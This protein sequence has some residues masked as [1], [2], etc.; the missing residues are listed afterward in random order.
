MAGGGCPP[1]A[2]LDRDAMPVFL[3]RQPAPRIRRALQCTHGEVWNRCTALA[4]PDP[5]RSTCGLAGNVC[6]NARPGWLDSGPGTRSAS[7]GGGVTLH[8]ATPCVQ[9]GRW[10]RPWMQ[11]IPAARHVKVLTWVRKRYRLS[12]SEALVLCSTWVV[13]WADSASGRPRHLCASVAY[14]RRPPLRHPAHGTQV[15]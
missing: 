8:H 11:Q 5:L 15:R 4:H 14:G 10:R 13:K 12:H 6:D 2:P 1:L 7:L 3:R 9:R